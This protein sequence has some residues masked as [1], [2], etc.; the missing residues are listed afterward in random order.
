M[1]IAAK[2]EL[3]ENILI[4]DQECFFCSNYVRL[5]KLRDAV[6]DIVLIN[7]RTAEAAEA[8]HDRPVDLNDG[9]LLILGDQRYFDADAIHHLALL[10]TP[11]AAFNRLNKA[12]F[13]NRWMARLLYPFLKLGRRIYLHVS[14]KGM[15]R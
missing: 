15:I 3:P 6:G 5:L 9:M 11:N 2:S 4:Y 10:S 13:R 7:A 8:L 12:I 1:Q 14:G